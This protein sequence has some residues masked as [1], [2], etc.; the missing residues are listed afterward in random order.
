MITKIPVGPPRLAINQGYGVLI[1]ENNGQVSFP[2]DKGFYHD[3]TR[4]ISSWHIFANGEEWKLL[5]GGNIAYFAHRIFLTNKTLH[6]ETGD[7]PE[8]SVALSIG[9]AISGGIHEDLDVV[10]HG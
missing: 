1:T 10:N 9:R 6:T 3:D 2:T 7:V 5:N 8:D 4:M